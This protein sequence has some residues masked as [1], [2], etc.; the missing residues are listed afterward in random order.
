MSS[1]WCDIDNALRGVVPSTPRRALDTA[2]VIRRVAH[3]P[4]QTERRLREV[5][6]DIPV[7]TQVR[8]HAGG[9]RRASNERPAQFCGEHGYSLR[10]RCA[11]RCGDRLEATG[12][13]GDGRA[14]GHRGG[15]LP[16]T[17]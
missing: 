17:P 5:N 10:A 4:R 3:D 1:Y 6:P 12:K 7:D 9:E 11:T 16:D 2:R 8:P 15:P 14:F 13:M